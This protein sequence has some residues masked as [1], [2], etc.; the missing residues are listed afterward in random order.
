M[1]SKTWNE[2]KCQNILILQDHTRQILPEMMLPTLAVLAPGIDERIMCSFK[3][4]W[5]IAR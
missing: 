4:K 5:L 2:A 1:L 3:I